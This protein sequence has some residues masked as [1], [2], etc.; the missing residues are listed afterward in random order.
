MGLE[1][2]EAAASAGYMA[3]RCRK[4]TRILLRITTR[5]PV[6]WHQLGAAGLVD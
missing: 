2:L 4:E 6:F 1:V 5:R 3:T